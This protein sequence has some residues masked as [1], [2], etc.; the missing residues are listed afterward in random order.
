MHPGPSLP[1]DLEREISETSA[2]IHPR[3]ITVLLRVARRVLIWI[4]PL[5][6]RTVV[7]KKPT[8]PTRVFFNSTKPAEFFHSTVRHLAVRPS[9]YAAEAGQLLG[10]CKGTVDLI[11]CQTVPY[12]SLL[13][14]LAQ[15]RIQRLAADLRNLFGGPIDPKHPFFA[16]L[17]HLRVFESDPTAMRQVWGQISGLPTLTHLCVNGQADRDDLLAMLAECPRLRLLLVLW[18]SFQ[19]SIY[20]RLQTPCVYDVRFVIC[21]LDL[22]DYWANW[23]AGARGFSDLWSQGDDFVARKRRGDIDATCYW[24]N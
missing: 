2:L 20:E 19:R 3:M 7:L 18:G 16:S 22:G 17:T 1:T 15:M 21:Q 13:P 11:W 12:D 6:Y 8:D 10:L 4:E 5:L 24:L 14:I 23:E 9:V